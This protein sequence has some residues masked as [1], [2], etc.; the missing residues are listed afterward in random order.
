VLEKLVL[1]TQ[2]RSYVDEGYVRMGDENGVL[3]LTNFDGARH[4]Y[5]PKFE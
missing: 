5:D 2:F 3:A 1:R 4:L